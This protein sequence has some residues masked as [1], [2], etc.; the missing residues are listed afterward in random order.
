MTS[1][2]EQLK[3]C[4][5][6]KLVSR[7]QSDSRHY[8]IVCIH[9]KYL[10]RFNETSDTSASITSCLR[11]IPS[12]Q[13]L[14]MSN[15]SIPYTSS[16]GA[17]QRFEQW[18]TECSVDESNLTE[19]NF[20]E[21]VC[22]LEWP[23]VDDDKTKGKSLV[24]AEINELGAQWGRTFVISSSTKRSF[25]LKCCRHGVASS[26][27]LPE[28]RIRDSS[29]NKIECEFHFLFGHSIQLSKVN[30]VFQKR[31]VWRV[32]S[33]HNHGTDNRHGHH[34]SCQPNMMMKIGG[35]AHMHQLTQPMI[36][37]INLMAAGG[38]VR[39]CDIR[40][41]L[42]REFGLKFI[43]FT[44]IQNVIN[45]GKPRGP[46]VPE[47]DTL[48]AY[49][50]ANREE[51]LFQCQWQQAKHNQ[52]TVL[53]IRNVF[54]T[55]KQM[56]KLFREY[57]QL[58]IVDAT[59]R[60]NN[61][62]MKLLL[63]TIRAGNG[64][65]TIVGAAL[66]QHESAEDLRWAFLELMKF[67]DMNVGTLSNKSSNQSNQHSEPQIQANSR[68][69]AEEPINQP[70]DLSQT[71]E[72]Q[73]ECV[74]ET[75]M[76]DGAPAYPSLLK[77][78]FPDAVH[79]LC[80]WHQQRLMRK[81]CSQFADDG[82]SAVRDLMDILREPDEKLAAEWWDDMMDEHFNEPL[83]ERPP[84]AANVKE[85]AKQTADRDEK[86]KKRRNARAL[87]QEWR[88]MAPKYWK[89]FTMNYRNLGSISSQGGEIMN[90][91]VKRRR[92]VTMTELIQMTNRVASNHM[93]DQ[94][95]SLNDASRIPLNNNI[96]LWTNVLRSV[97]SAYASEELTEQL[98][99]ALKY[100]WTLDDNGM[101][102]TNNQEL[103]VSLS[104]HS[105]SCGYVKQH[106]LTCRHL[107][108][109]QMLNEPVVIGDDGKVAA[110]SNNMMQQLANLCM[111]AAHRRWTHEA[112][113]RVI[114]DEVE[115][116]AGT[117]ENNAHEANPFGQDDLDI[118]VNRPPTHVPTS[119][120]M[121]K[122]EFEDLVGRLRRFE[123]RDKV[124]SELSIIILERAV[125]QAEE[126]YTEKRAGDV[127]MVPSYPQPQQQP[128]R[129]EKMQQ[130]EL[131]NQELASPLV[132]TDT[133][134]A[135]MIMKRVD[136]ILRRAP[137]KSA[138]NPINKL[139]RTDKI[140]KKRAHQE[141][142][143]REKLAIQQ[144]EETSQDSQPDCGTSEQMLTLDFKRQKK[145]TNNIAATAN[146]M[147]EHND[148]RDSGQ[149]VTDS[150]TAVHQTTVISS[151]TQSSTL[152]KQAITTMKKPPRHCSACGQIG[153]TSNNRKCSK[154]NETVA[155]MA[156][157]H[158]QMHRDP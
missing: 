8:D 78:L 115:L 98:K 70:A 64:R 135:S 22:S 97:L 87:L 95:R 60:S 35:I 116:R 59:Y 145:H 56:M 14:S 68:S 104:L 27:V 30:G 142:I 39:P 5:S 84:P 148:V 62:N 114:D 146:G 111:N 141:S 144:N 151:T 118:L 58:L 106:G 91:A 152:T 6:L 139:S 67:A 72:R 20:P 17:V 73:H 18:N 55:T 43:D 140:A 31:H 42:Q 117:D 40:T 128:A 23:W 137:L 3:A 113:S 154:Y 155:S 4:D 94:L 63:F 75:I 109:L 130:S 7:S 12:T 101:M 46:K 37:A 57:G 103:S 36:D 158:A 66:V 125:I 119:E 74:I 80:F 112:V 41:T 82:A 49:F 25:Y 149:V 132:Q 153:H 71:S 107:M 129:D 121:R 26:R 50:Q 79:Q 10:N 47:I 34:D 150:E 131:T 89:C 9:C 45:I 134:D 65:F 54:W 77:E 93:F 157:V 92:H 33:H 133:L 156:Y 24:T 143:K 102:Q 13:A 136:P 61:F 52:E 44:L 28:Y 147:S 96:A 124:A 99:A 90:N 81:F 16:P 86:N 48:L 2:N 100:R 88:T 29:S 85:T 122:L 108:A 76:T 69:E 110:P 38:A 105:C 123:M 11:S 21:Y 138:N 15:S 53:E 32:T 83:Q 120:V 19:S 1:S 126:M 51:I 127:E